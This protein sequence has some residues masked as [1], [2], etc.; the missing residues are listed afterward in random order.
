MH[1]F[2]VH[3]EGDDDAVVEAQAVQAHVG[4]SLQRFSMK[5]IISNLDGRLRTE[6]LIVRLPV[7]EAWKSDGYRIGLATGHGGC[8]KFRLE[9]TMILL[10]EPKIVRCTFCLLLKVST[11]SHQISAH[12][13]RRSI[14]N[15]RHYGA[16][17]HRSNS[18]GGAELYFGSLPGYSYLSSRVTLS[19]A[20]RPRS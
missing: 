4:M 11:S 8:S 17:G 9:M 10:K 18:K 19:C 13:G 7:E 6:M 1:S 2:T 16:S 12:T 3:L 14:Q 5:F 20:K 15:L